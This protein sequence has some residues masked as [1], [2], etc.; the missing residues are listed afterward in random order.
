MA[1]TV[2]A[3]D[4]RSRRHPSID[5]DRWADLARVAAEAEGGDGEL[6]LN[7]V[8][9]DEI[10]RLNSEHMGVDGPTDV[11]NLYVP[12]NRGR[13]TDRPARSRPTSRAQ[14]NFDRC[15]RRPSPN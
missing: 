12:M 8:D 2:A 9:A 6:T 1:V 15:A 7:F 3:A 11:R 10:S 5:V 4:G 14:L 13:S